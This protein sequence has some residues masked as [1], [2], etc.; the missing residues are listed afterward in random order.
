MEARNQYL[1]ALRKA[2]ERAAGRQAKH[3]LLDEAEERTGLNRKVLIR[4]LRA[5]VVRRKPGRR[6]KRKATYDGAVAAVLVEVWECSTTP[7]GSGWPG[8]RPSHQNRRDPASTDIAFLRHWDRSFGT[9][10]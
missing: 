9:G 1:E 3:Q 8:G 10:A 6:G 5:P 4:K 7:V 2:Y